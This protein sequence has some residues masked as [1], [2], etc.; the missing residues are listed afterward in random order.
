M[1][2]SFVENILFTGTIV[3]IVVSSYANLIDLFENHVIIKSVDQ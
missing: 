2:S 1:M 3:M